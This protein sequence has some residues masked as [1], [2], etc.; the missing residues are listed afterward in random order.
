MKSKRIIFSLFLLY[1][2]LVLILPGQAQAATDGYYTYEVT[3]DEVTITDVEASI[4]G[5]VSIPSTL[6]GYPVTAIGENAFAECKNLTAVTMPDSVTHMGSGAFSGCTSLQSVKI[7]KGVT[8]IE[9]YLFVSCTSLTDVELPNSI[10]KIGM[11][12]FAHCIKLESI[13]LPDSVTSIGSNAWEGCGNLKSINIPNGVTRI[14]REVFFGCRSLTEIE[15]PSNVTVISHKAFWGCSGLTE[16]TIPNSVQELGQQAFFTCSNLRRIV[17]SENITDIGYAAFSYCP[18]LEEIA[19]PHGVTT[20]EGETFCG[21]RALS[22]VVIPKSVT[23]IDL[24]AFLDCNNLKTVIYCGAKIQ[25]DVISISRYNDPLKNA[26]LQYHSYEDG[27]CSYCGEKDSDAAVVVSSGSCGENVTWVLTDDGT[28]TISGSGAMQDYSYSDSHWNRY[29]SH[30]QAAVLESGVTSIGEYAFAECKNMTAVTIPDSVTRMGSRAFS[31]CTS[32]Q[33]VKIP[34]GVTVIE[35]SLFCGCR[36]LTQVELPSNIIEI[37]SAAF[38]HCSKLESITLPDSVTTIGTDAFQNC[39]QLKSINIPDGITRIERSTFWS[40]LSLTEIVIPDSVTVIGQAAFQL[41][42]ALTDVKMPAGLQK[43][44]SM[45]FCG[46]SSLKQM[47][48]PESV[49]SIGYGA[50]SN[51]ISLE[52]I[53]IPS[54]VTRIEGESFFMCHSLTSI[55]IPEGVSYIEDGAIAECINLTG[56]WVSEENPY[57]TNDAWGVLYTKDKTHLMQAPGLLPSEYQIPNSV[58]SIS[59]DAF[60]KCYNLTTVAIPNGVTQIKEQTFSGCSALSTVVIPK[61]VTTID[62]YAF[63]NCNNLK[64]VIYC[65]TKKQWDAISISS[66]NQPLT[67][68]TLQYHSYENHKCS[69]CGMKDTDQPIDIESINGISRAKNLSLKD[70]IYIKATVAFL[71]DKGMNTAL[72]KADVLKNGRILF[73]SQKDTPTD[74]VFS[75]N[76]ATSVQKLADAG[77]YT[78]GIQEYYAYSHGIAAAEYG[79]RIFYCTYIVIDGVEYYGDLNQY[80]VATYANNQFRKTNTKL[81]NLLAAMLNYGAAAQVQFGYKTNDLVNAS[82]QYWVDQGQL[83]ADAVALT[84]DSS[85]LDTPADASAAMATNFAQNNAKRTAASLSLQSMVQPKLTFAYNLVDGKGTQLPSGGSLTFYYWSGADYAALESQGTALTR[86]NAT[87]TLSGK[88]ITENYTD[89]Y[90]YEYAAYF[91][92][93]PAK[94]LGNAMYVAAVFTLA[95]GTE[96]CSGV[97]VYSPEVY[98]ANQLKK[99]TVSEN[100]KDLLKWMTVYGEAAKNY[101][102]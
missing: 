92:G 90:G 66:D 49:T 72:P 74:D 59:R 22:T 44:G 93:I 84:W 43:V 18:S 76:N 20:I 12:A 68:A 17:L 37:Q 46:C 91:A 15:I 83:S 70:V 96:Y 69:Y 60:Q 3:N 28:L 94:E 53:N 63:W 102:G 95:D 31:D 98:V 42:S 6:G 4:S 23:A 5:V 47:V 34:E 77:V 71:D 101:Y 62:W 27:Q 11:S 41:C 82:L 80:S 79:D 26:T 97:T 65:G 81:K 40:C 50:F 19:I 13:K 48:L 45:A 88:A 52:E 75:F 86:A 16:V 87:Y 7:P 89:K 29:A 32:L 9:D 73:W 21:C 56:I 25:W 8:V 38:M 1:L 30:I 55:T 64:T 35:G 67:N 57:Y 85:L 33:S 2:V 100:T 54:G 78:D 61:S 10:T 24:Y 39:Q 36:G 14:E 51:C 58:Q 99:T